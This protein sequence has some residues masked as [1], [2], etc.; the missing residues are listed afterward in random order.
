MAERE[1]PR[2]VNCG[3]IEEEVEDN[4]LVQYK[5]NEDEVKLLC[6]PCMHNAMPEDP[7]NSKWEVVSGDDPRLPK[8]KN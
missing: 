8:S 4:L 5:Y 1:E 6:L 7:P 3:K 2:C